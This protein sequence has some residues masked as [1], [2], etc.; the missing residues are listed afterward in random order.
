MCKTKITV[1]VNGVVSTWETDRDDH[2]I[3]EVLNGF[4]GTLV[5][6]T[7]L[8]ITILEGMRDYAEEQLECLNH[9]LS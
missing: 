3:D 9:E 5:A 1:E 2:S 4:A 7:W 8:P 6:Q